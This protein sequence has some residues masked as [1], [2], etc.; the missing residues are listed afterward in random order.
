MEELVNRTLDTCGGLHC[1]FNNA[2]ILPPTRPLEN[3]TKR[4]LTG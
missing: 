1:A 4:P 3:R 2:G